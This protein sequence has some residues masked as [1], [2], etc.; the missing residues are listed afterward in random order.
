MEVDL[1]RIKTDP[2]EDDVT[3]GDNGELFE[4]GGGDDDDYD[5][6][7]QF[8]DQFDDSGAA[9][10]SGSGDSK[11]KQSPNPG[12]PYFLVYHTKMGVFRPKFP[13]EGLTKFTKI[14]IFGMQV[15]HLATLAQ[16]S[17]CASTLHTK[18]LSNIPNVAALSTQR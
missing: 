17:R 15:Y 1:K 3:G 18:L 2:D 4:G 14:D 9:G 6:L 5:G 7:G 10:P 11:G 16:S 13:F 8:D 12:L